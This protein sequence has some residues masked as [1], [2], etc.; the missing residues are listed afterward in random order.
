VPARS[1]LLPLLLAL[2]ACQSAP[3]T[4]PASAGPPPDAPAV[5]PEPALPAA[6]EVASP[7]TPAPDAAAPAERVAARHILVSYVG[8]V[9]TPMNVRRSEDDARRKAAALLER[10]RAGEDFAAMARDESDDATRAR[11]GFLGGFSRGT[12]APAFEQATFAL[13]VGGT[14]EVVQTPFGFHIIRR[15]PLDEVHVAQILVQWQGATGASVERT[16]QAARLRIEEAW[17][18]LQGGAAFSEVART[19]SDGAAGLRGGDLGWSTRGQF[20]PTW[21]EKAFALA[22]GETCP[23]FETSV[24]YHIL[25]RLE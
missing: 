13:P 12:M 8:T 21:E 5:A 23:P 17:S 15:E 6:L 16:Q 24:G 25:E 3:S 2:V 7:P 11:G 20:L 9:G 1:Y 4:A 19:H 14:S 22:P 18:L 10:L